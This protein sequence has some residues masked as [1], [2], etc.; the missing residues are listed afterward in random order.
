MKNEKITNIED[1]IDERETREVNKLFEEL[2]QDG[3]IDIKMSSKAIKSREA[4]KK[5]KKIIEGSK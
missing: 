4:L 5:M 2:K 3:I 1:E